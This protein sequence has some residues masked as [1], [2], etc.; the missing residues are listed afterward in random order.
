MFQLWAKVALVTSAGHFILAGRQDGICALF[1]LKTY[2]T[3]V[4]RNANRFGE[5]RCALK[6]L[7]G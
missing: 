7:G 3:R 4:Q 1:A 6:T 5:T 2:R